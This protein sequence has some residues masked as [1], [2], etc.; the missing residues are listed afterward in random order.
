MRR[1]ENMADIQVNLVEKK[2]RKAKSHE[3]TLRIRDDLTAIAEKHGAVLSIAEAP[4]GPPVIATLVAEVYGQPRHSYD[5]LQ[6]AAKTV[7][8]RMTAEPGVVDVDDSIQ[9]DQ[10]KLVFVTDKEKAALNGTSVS[11][12]ARTMQLALEGTLGGTVRKP[13]ER[14]PLRIELRLPEPI[15]ST[16]LDLTQIRVKG[17]NGQ[18]VPLS[19]LGEWKRTTINKMIFHKNLEPVVYVF[20]E[21]AGRP[22]A[23]TV[24]DL[25]ADHSDKPSPPQ[26][27]RTAGS[28]WVEDAEPRSVEARTFWSDGSGIEWFVPEGIRVKWDGEGEW[29]TTLRVFRDLG[30]AFAAALVGIY[31]LLVGQTQSFVIPIVVMMAIPLT[32]LGIM[33]GFWLL[34]VIAGQQVGV[35]TSPIFFT[36]TGMIGMIALAGIV[37]RDSIILVDFIHLSL[38]RGRTLFDAIMESRVVRLRPILLTTVTAM[39]S[40]I[41]ITTDPVFSGLAWALIFGLFASTLFTLFVIPITYW[42]LYENKPGHGLP[43]K[44]VD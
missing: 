36:A 31:I 17:A 2:T 15:R 10:Q 22:P 12:I 43:Q 1:G 7:R 27:H 19:E 28:G 16:P 14:N 30:L 42:L 11:E 34:N 44:H 24:V 6:K 4:P 21:V 35:Y 13:D 40:A 25:M 20:A 8:A 18:L 9:A 5:E 23:D 41:P 39:L 38:S 33:P 29:K 3:I 26:N 32:V 37:T